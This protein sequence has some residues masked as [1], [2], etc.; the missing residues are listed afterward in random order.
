MTW[1]AFLIFAMAYFLPYL[2]AQ[3][4]H[5]PNRW[6]ILVLNLFLGWTLVGWVVSLAWSLTNVSPDR[7]TQWQP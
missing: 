5:N 7:Q 4:R 1:L 3:H 2:I 6:A